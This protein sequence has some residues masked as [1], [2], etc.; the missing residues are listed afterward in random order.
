MILAVERNLLVLSGRQAQHFQSEEFEGAEKLSA[1]IEEK[2]G[3]GAGEIDENFG[4]LPIAILGQRR[5]DNDAVFQA[6]A[7]VIDDGL[8]ESVDLVSGGDFVGNGHRFSF[9]LSAGSF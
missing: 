3:V 7:T 9:Q 5:V 8:E 2:S 6:K 4:L 1:T